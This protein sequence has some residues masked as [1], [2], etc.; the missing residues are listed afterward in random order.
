MERVQHL[1]FVMI[2]GRICII[3]CFSLGFEERG[4]GERG[5]GGGD[6]EDRVWDK[7][8]RVSKVSMKV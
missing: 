7:L 1:V 6:G 4:P 3:L 2:A 8:E 5:R